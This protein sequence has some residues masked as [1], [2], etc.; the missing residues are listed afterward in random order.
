[1]S[2][3]A[4][5]VVQDVP[6]SDTSAED[7]LPLLDFLAPVAGFP[8]HRRFV[9]AELDE[10]S[11]LRALRSLDDPALRFLVLPPGPFFPDYDPEIGDDWAERLELT[12]SD[13]ALVLVLI[14]PG[15]TAAEATA[16]LLAPVVI[17]VRT[18]RAAQIVLDDSSLPLRAP[19]L[20]AG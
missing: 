11:L 16:N 18:R 13:D 1:M 7:E 14:T 3:T 2:G 20:T 10:S 5:T 6:M 4:S 8:E 12:S 15:A 17:N 19:L 9:L